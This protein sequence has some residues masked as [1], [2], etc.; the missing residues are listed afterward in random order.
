MA[1]ELWNQWFFKSARTIAKYAAYKDT[2]EQTTA[3]DVYI[4]IITIAFWIALSEWKGSITMVLGITFLSL[5]T[6]GEVPHT[7]TYLY[8]PRDVHIYTTTSQMW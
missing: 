1:S 5:Y 3:N 6:R 7:K 4:N 2:L 8:V